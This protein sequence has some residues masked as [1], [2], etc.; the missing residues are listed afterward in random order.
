MKQNYSITTISK[1]GTTCRFEIRKTNVK[2]LRNLLSIL[3]LSFITNAA[4]AQIAQRGTATTATANAVTTLTINKP[5][6]VI[7]GDIMIVNITQRGTNTLSN[8]TCT[9][10]TS[11]DGANLGG[12]TDRR[13]SVL[14]KIAGVSEPANYTFNLDADVD[15]S[16][17]A[18]LAFSGVDNTT[19]FDVTLGTINTANSTTV[20]AT[21]ITT[22]TNNAAVIMLG[23]SGGSTWS[24]WTTTSPGGLTELYDI[25]NTVS[26]GGAWALKATAGATGN[27][28]STLTSGERNGAILVALRA[29]V[30]PPANDVCS[31]AILLT[32][33]T[34]CTTT[35]GST[36]GAT[37]NNE[38]GDCTI[39]TENAVWYEFQAVATSHVV[40]VDGIANFDAVVEVI[41]TCGSATTPTGGTC[42]DNTL[43]DGI[44]TL[45]LTGLT[46]GNYYKIQIHDYYGDLTANGFTVCVTHVS[47]PTIT[48]LGAAG[49]CQGSSLTINGTD[50]TGATAVTIGGTAATI[51]GSTATTVT[52]T[53]GSGTTGTVQVTT[54]GGT[55]TSAATFTVTP[56]PVITTQPVGTSIC[57]TG[58]GSFS[59]VTAPATSY[60][61]R[62]NGVNL[63][64][65]APY[66]GVTTATLTITNPAAG[67]AGNFD[68]VITNGTCSVTSALRTLTV[69]T[70]P[71]TVATPTPV[72][73]ATG[74]CYAGG[75]TVSS[76]SWG[77]AA[78][79]TSYDVYF[80]A[81]SVPGSVTSN[82]ATNSYNTGALAA[83]TTYYWRIVAKNACGD[84]ITSATF[85]FTTATTPCA[86]T[87]C[88]PAHSSSC[89]NTITNVTFN[90]INNT[91]GCAD[92]NGTSYTNYATSGTPTS[93][94]LIGSTY[95]LSITTNSSSIVSAWIDFNANGTFEATEW[96]QVFTTG[97]NGN[98][99]IL[100]PV[101]ATP[102]LTTIRIRSRASGN[103]NGSGN[104]CTSFA[105]GETED[106]A[107]TLLTPPACIT[108][109]A[110]PTALMLT[111]SGNSIAGSFAPSVPAADT[112]LVVINTTNVAPNPTNGTTYTV[113]GTVGAGNTVL[114]INSNTTFVASGLTPSTTYYFFVFAY[115]SLCTGGPLYNTT[116]PLNGTTTTTTA[117]PVYCTPSVGAAGD[118]SLTYFTSISF[119][120]TL[121]DISNSSTYSSAPRGYQDFSTIASRSRQAQ[122]QGVNI[123]TQTTNRGYL[124]AWVDW[125]KDGDFVD[126]GE[127][128]YDVGGIASY[129]TTFGFVIPAVQPVGNYR[130]R[131]RIN[132]DDDTSPYDP[133]AIS[134]F[135]SCQN[136]DYYGETEDY[137]FTV[138]ASC[139]ATITSITDGVNCGAGNVVLGAT[140]A[141][142]PTEYRWYTT[143]VGGTPLASTATGSWTTP[144][145]A[146]TTTYWVTA[147]NGCESLTRTKVVATISPLATLSFTPSVPEVCGE[148]NVLSLTA[149]GDKQLTYL[150]NE[151]F[152]AGLGVMTNSNI[153]S[154]GGAIDAIS[155][156]QN[157]ASTF[158][159]SEQVWF[160]AIASGLT[161]NGFAMSTSDTGEDVTHN[162][163]LSPTISTNT[164]LDLSLSFDI[165]YSRYYV[166]G[167]SLG[168]DY[169]TVDVSTNGGGAWTEIDRYTADIGYGTRFVNKSYNLNA[170]TN[171]PNFKVR[172]RYY[173]EWCDGLAIDNFKL[174]GNVPLSTSFDWSS[175]TPVAAFQ[176]ASCTIPYVTGTPITTV[177]IRPTLAQLED[178]T[179][180]FTAT[181]TLSNGCDVSQNVSIN[182]KSKVWKGGTDGDWNNANNWLPVG[183]PDANTCVIIP[184][185]PN[186]S[187]VIG[188]NYN[189]YGKTLQVKDGGTLIINPSNSVTITDFVEVSPTG[190]F[191][192]KNTGSLVQINNVA[193][194]GIINMERISQPMYRLDYTYWN[195]PVTAA[196]GFTLG[197]LTTATSN[198]YSYTP[199]QAGANGIWT[200]Q[201]AATVMNPTKGYIARAPLSFPS[202]G[203]KLAQTVNFVGTPN[204]GNI[205]MPI[206]KGTNANV[207]TSVGGAIITDADDEWNLIGNPYPSAID[208]VS[209]LNNPANTSIVDGTVYL[210]THN[211]PPLA[212]TP[213]PFY[214][215]YALNYTVNDYAT[216]NSLGSTTTAASG[217]LAPTRY[218]GA[219]QSFFISADDTM[220]NGTTANAIFN[221]S[222]RVTGNNDNF[223]RTENETSHT[224]EFASQR[225]WLNLS[226]NHGGF[227]QILI[228]YA[229]GAS[230][231]WDRGLDGE[232]LAGN[233]V[234]F[235]SFTED[236][237]LT[238]QGR[239]WPFVQDD[240]VPLGFKSTAQDNYTIG[241]DHIDQE[242]NS[243][244]IYLEDRLLNV[245]HNLRTAP[246]SFTAQQGTFDTRFVLRYTENTLSNTEITTV[247]N[248][249]FVYNNGKINIKSNLEA[250][251][252]VSV[253]DVLGK[254]IGV[255]KKINSSDFE[256]KNIL[257]TTKTLIIKIELENGV[258][259]TKKILF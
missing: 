226:N 203:P 46:I 134:T 107:V 34:T 120:G 208:I 201:S 147:F 123:S 162:A 217:G 140:G 122:G 23:G 259:I 18:I 36:S 225:V 197:N 86:L 41:S 127:T 128:V 247:E 71:S 181:A 51:T 155:E 180:S 40:T 102:G 170:Y 174:F 161:G 73:G 213:D 191:N 76:I 246:Y 157:Q 169:V 179:Y 13:V 78:G 75:G 30:P 19:P 192:I 153:V 189:G 125:N 224:N 131:I 17:G 55:A 58:T 241:I 8:P 253:F 37:D 167:T 187:N 39:G 56:L 10:W 143:E 244:N 212:T 166:D 57:T 165:Y 54:P 47:Q 74:V 193:N 70:V 44:E 117:D 79:A 220:A 92:T 50:L 243:Q 69:T 207:G 239:P 94:L 105:S 22:A 45:T 52:V 242:F 35:I 43:D 211:T 88:V 130:I 83:N 173:G 113:G 176:D 85:S 77:A 195:S 202:T 196:S 136:I 38:T 59:V 168:L 109:N 82:V 250:I 231:G 42:I 240:I 108:P 64:D 129:S 215:N 103:T 28:I 90:T 235:Y 4:N 204:N 61:W 121:N 230:L 218:I 124:K 257:P 245:I 12:G 227:S 21:G 138:I 139:S 119:V 198:I 238:I 15:K 172:I 87:Y 151:L 133:D 118:E 164:Y 254:A 25:Q 183:V 216:V 67:D 185:A 60:Q 142:A 141:G 2:F 135:N 163:I 222:M 152:N 63:T 80:G 137:T 178:A 110:Q 115:N 150:V 190:I 249:V 194:T 62:R 219:G 114:S 81:G 99:N 100:I 95:N 27:G 199:T 252:E 93:T 145:L 214:G 221:N 104:P 158:V 223:F 236:R 84:A 14:Y 24:G 205:S 116:T 234:K 228:G 32:S 177:Y 200:R 156:W 126:A 66:S 106:Y 96:T 97:T 5:T 91:T 11:I 184:P 26:I 182:N 233:A 149:T 48:S 31:G 7:A 186:T 148:N 255:Y 68:V 16:A 175:A 3:F 146:T 188:T 232:A 171:Q 6:G 132:K 210:W 49:G 33:N 251:N 101:T 1:R 9:G 89:S 209:F 65:T 258:L 72:N 111:P 160:P 256:I 98:V 229:E 206:S 154:N 112:Y 20:T 237:K 29:Y 144:V 159:P 248:S 53:V